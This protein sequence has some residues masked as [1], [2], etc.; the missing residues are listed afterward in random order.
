MIQN[1]NVFALLIGVGDYNQFNIV[2]LPT[3]NMDVALLG[4]S[5]LSGLKVP[6]DNIR[7]MTGQDNNGFVSTTDFARAIANFKNMLGSEDTFICYFSGHGR[8]GN[9]LFSNGQLNLQSMIDYIGTLPTKNKVVFLDCCY[10]GRFETAGASRMRFEE[11]MEQFANHGIAIFASS[12]ANEVS[13][14]GPNGTHSMFTG[15]LS[16]AII[17]NKNIREGKTSLNDI[18]HETM[19]LVS[20]WNA[21]NPGK[22]QQ[23]IFRSSMGGTVFFRVEEYEPYEQK[24]V[25]YVAK[26]YKV[27]KVEPI[28]SQNDKRL[29]AFVILNRKM[30]YEE[31]SSITDTIANDIRFEEVHSN[32]LGEIKFSGKPARAVWCYF[33]YD[34]DDIVNSN[35]WAYTIWAAD[36]EMK[37]IFFREVKN[38]F[39][40]N[41]IYIYKN[42][43]YELVKR[44]QSRT[45]TREEFIA[46]NKKMLAILV[47]LAEKFIVDLQEVRNKTIAISVMRDKYG[48]WIDEVREQYIRLS[49]GD[50][51]PNDLHDWSEEIT[52]LA[53][54]VLDCALLL[55]NENGG[56]VITDRERWLIDNALQH[57]YESMEKIKKLEKVLEE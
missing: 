15:A 13:R 11:S 40:H 50:V 4:T 6:E 19:H 57:Y 48:N 37:R 35:H 41:G 44:M 55:D 54:W 18:Y 29:C 42:T 26:D 1:N 27:I 10:S 14:L 16:T 52:S 53:G 45:Q 24:E 2:N 30:D 23:P 17:M 43:S 3:F 33:G 31:L 7:L 12:A 8:D 5:L 20:A 25:S 39:V 22:E 51:P 34:D 38:S 56:G 46:E 36:D 32:R 47:N 28:S 9:I 21:N 49:D